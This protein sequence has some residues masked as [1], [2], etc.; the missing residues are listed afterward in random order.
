MRT[1]TEQEKRTVRFASWG[2][3][4]YLVL[5]GGFQVWKHL[6]ARRADYRKLVAEAVELNDKVKRYETKVQILKNL[7]EEFHIDP[8]KLSK[9]TVVGEAS[10][11][12]QRAATSSGV[13]VGPVRESAA[14]PSSREL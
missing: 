8:A 12:I 1:L 10:A 3:G 9:A 14:R 4:T 7:M 2:I 6:D 11:A 13:Q 5:F